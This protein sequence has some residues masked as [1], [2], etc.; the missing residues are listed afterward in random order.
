MVGV[1][2]RIK[3]IYEGRKVKGINGVEGPRRLMKSSGRIA[4]RGSMVRNPSS[5]RGNL[6]IP[7]CGQK[8]VTPFWVKRTYILPGNNRGDF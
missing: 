8:A 2:R 5:W 4:W 3:E 6:R 1:V 7:S